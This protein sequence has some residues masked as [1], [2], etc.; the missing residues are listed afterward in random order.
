MNTLL[1]SGLLAALVVSA[2]ACAT[3]AGPAARAH[4]PAPPPGSAVVDAEYVATVDYIARRR[5]VTVR[6]VNP[7]MKR[8]GAVASR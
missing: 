3:T 7:P 4:P 8:V 6:W 2:T 5:G 1:R